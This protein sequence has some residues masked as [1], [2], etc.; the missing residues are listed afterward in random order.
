M[1]TVG[2]DIDTRAYFTAATMIIAVPTGIKI[3]SWI[4][5]MWGGSIEFKTPML[6]AVGFLFLF[7]VGGLTGVILANSG[8]DIALHDRGNKKEYLKQFWVGLMDGDGSVQVNHWR[9]K[10]LEYRI[11]IK[12][13]RLPENISMLHLM[14][15]VIGGYVRESSGCVL[16]IEN[17]RTKIVKILK[18]FER[19]PPLTTRLE[20]QLDFLY[21]CLE[22]KDSS[23][24]LENRG[25]K[26]NSK[27]YK[28]NQRQRQHLLREIPYF[29][30]WLSGFVE[31]EGCFCVRQKSN[32]S[33]RIGQLCDNYLINSI[34]SYFKANNMT[35]E[36]K[37]PFSESFYLW[38]VYKKHVLDRI[39]NHFTI[40]PLLGSKRSQ[41][42]LFSERS[43]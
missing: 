33:F 3:F 17:D 39:I 12:L 21:A 27:P 29:P 42:L 30:G 15:N 26:Y 9:K 35:R 10:S 13:K 8:I 5:T 18:V 36:I 25:K 19:Y 1:Y 37:K 24:Y 31:A 38:E 2:L 41:Y 43:K 22:R 16:W 6:F 7:T 23:W 14:T 32:H 11:V 40:Y 28:L 34:K 4:A 20:C